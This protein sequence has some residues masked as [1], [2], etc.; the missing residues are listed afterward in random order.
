LSASTGPT[1]LGL[2]AV[3]GNLTTNTWG[4][5]RTIT[6]ADQFPNYFGF[7]MSSTGKAIAF[8]ALVDQSSNTTWRA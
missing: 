5:V 1:F 2:A 7:A 4:T 6:G 8:Y 3:D